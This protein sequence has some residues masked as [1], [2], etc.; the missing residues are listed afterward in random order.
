MSKSL[1]SRRALHRNPFARRPDLEVN[2]RIQ[3]YLSFG[4]PVVW[5][6]DSADKTVWTYRSKD[7]KEVRESVKLDG[8]SIEIPFSEIFD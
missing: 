2:Q 8:T 3:E 6:I 4:V 7:M 1:R 5:L